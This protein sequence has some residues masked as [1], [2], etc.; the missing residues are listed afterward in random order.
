[1]LHDFRSSRIHETLLFS[2]IQEY[3]HIK[4][5][6]NHVLPSRTPLLPAIRKR[7]FFL[8]ASFCVEEFGCSFLR[9]NSQAALSRLRLRRVDH[10]LLRGDLG[11]AC[12]VWLRF[13]RSACVVGA[14]GHLGATKTYEKLEEADKK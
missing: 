14:T 1:M 11:G 3:I 6:S 10:G 12:V 7:A 8:I 2:T 13:C 4:Q 5:H 9:K